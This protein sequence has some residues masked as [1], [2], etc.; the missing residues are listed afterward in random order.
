MSKMTEFID[1]RG[2]RYLNRNIDD[3]GRYYYSLF[4]SVTSEIKFMSNGGGFG[5]EFD[6]HNSAQQK[7]YIRII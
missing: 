6:A 4:R 7:I 1:K 3:T 5:V 2:S